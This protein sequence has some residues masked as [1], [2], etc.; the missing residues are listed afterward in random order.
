VRNEPRVDRVK[1]LDAYLQGTSAVWCATMLAVLAW[2]VTSSE[3]SNGCRE[4]QMNRS[5]SAFM[6]GSSF[7]WQHSEYQSFK[8]RS[9]YASNM[10]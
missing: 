5:R 3:W 8:M 4:M 7:G 10:D 9:H 6:I 2:L 1:H